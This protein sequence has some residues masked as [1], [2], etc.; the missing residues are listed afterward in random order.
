MAS[1][2]RTFTPD[3]R[4]TNDNVTYSTNTLEAAMT[5]STQS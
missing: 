3:V 2:I 4:T 5:S 1:N